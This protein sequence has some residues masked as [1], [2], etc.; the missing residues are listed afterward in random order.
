MRRVGA[1]RGQRVDGPRRSRSRWRPAPKCVHQSE[2]GYGAALRSGFEAAR[3]EY[4]VMADA[5]GTYEM[6]A[7]PRLLQPLIDD[8]ADL[9]MGSRLDAATKVST[10][11][12]LH[13]YLGTPMHHDARQPRRRA[14]A[15]RST[16]ASRGSGRCAASQFLAARPQRRPA[17]SS[18]PRC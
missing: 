5:D 1:R 7:I 16:T 13:R 17:W 14:A 10:M 3:T 6:R 15:R 4:V 18:R 9:V 8:E 2:P 12:W 11:P